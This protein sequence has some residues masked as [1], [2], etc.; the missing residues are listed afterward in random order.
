MPLRGLKSMKPLSERKKRKLI[1]KSQRYSRMAGLTSLRA[2][3]FEG[4]LS[5]VTRLV[6][7]I[8]D[9]KKNVSTA[10]DTVKSYRRG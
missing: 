6:Y 1:R 3:H 10:N 7:S 5:G 9:R 4:P 2:R 8:N